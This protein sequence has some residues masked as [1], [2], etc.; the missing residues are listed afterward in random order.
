MNTS[1]W[2][3]LALWDQN[4]QQQELIIDRVFSK[5]GYQVPEVG[6]RIP[7]KSFPQLSHLPD[8]T[9]A[10]GS[11]IVFVHPIQSENYDW[12]FLVLVGPLE[13][14]HYLFI[15][16]LG[17]HTYTILAAALE[18]EFLFKH[19]R[20]I[21]ERLEIVSETT[22]DGIWDWN[23]ITNKV[24]YN[25]R[26]Y[27]MLGKMAGDLSSDPQDL[28]N[29]I[30]P[31]D[32]DA[33]RNGILEHV[34]H[35]TPF[36][37]EFRIRRSDSSG[38]LWLYSTG[39]AIRNETG[40]GI[41]MIGSFTDI[42]KRKEDE[43]RIRRLAYHDTLT[44]LPNR[45]KFLDKLQTSMEH[46]ESDNSKLAVVMIDLDRFKYINDTLGHHSGDTLLQHI[47]E[48]LNQSVRDSD[49]IARLG[50]DEFIILLS[51]LQ[52]L[53]EAEVI[54]DRIIER[55][56]QPLNLDGEELFTT[57]SI[58]VCL[59]PDHGGDCNTL[60]KYADMAMYKAKESGR[61]QMIV[62]TE[63]L[64]SKVKQNYNLSTNLRKAIERNEFSLHY[65]PQVDLR[66]GSVIG[67][68]AL[69]RWNSPEYGMVPPGEFIPYAEESG[70]IVPISKWVLKEAC[71]QLMKW[72][73]QRF[74]TLVMSV[75]ISAQQFRSAGFSKWI[76]SVLDETGVDP[77]LL[78]LEITETTAIQDMEH[79]V[80]MLKEI[81]HL[82][83]YIAID[84]F[85]TGYSSLVLLKRLPIHMVKIDKSFIRDMSGDQDDAAIVKAVIAMSHSL[86]LSVIA[87]G[88][89]GREQLEQLKTLECDY[90]QGYYLGKPMPSDAFTAYIQSYSKDAVR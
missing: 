41:R 78:C 28:L 85:G 55:I 89:E 60:I 66:S 4:S 82:G 2:G 86:G 9:Q 49:T 63:E 50:G 30:H 65:Q 43:E 81:V 37:L 73:A 21:A 19:I 14:L 71:L 44:G 18:R 72:Q 70:L 45:L 88:V 23:I 84:D 79:S 48:M 80:Q 77:N 52:D 34:D 68:E 12:G 5:K 59:F 7:I 3:Y 47:A 61:N 16:D 20:S 36:Q 32:L 24:E 39:E 33:F 6:E 10:G 27:N 54:V 31:D 53:D 58:G 25:F 15:N 1:H 40:K 35:K 56:S 51:P 13:T 42:T 26:I 38:Y 69:I 46:C 90:I 75:N 62:Y 8:S 74:P 64:S 11:D 29:L 87:E 83:L 67:V 22:N 17:R 57:A 76:K